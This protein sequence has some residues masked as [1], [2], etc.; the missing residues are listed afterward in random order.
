MPQLKATPASALADEPVHI[1][2]T[3]LPPMQLVTLTAS[4]KDE[5]G[6]LFRS[7]AFYKA[8]EAGELD[9]QEAPSLGGDYVGVHPMGL[10]WS[11]KPER[12]FRRLLK[13]DVMSSP[14]SVTLDIYNSV[15]LLESAMVQPSASQVVQR[16]FRCPGTQRVQIWE[17]RLRGA[18][19]LP[20]GEGPFPGIIDLFGGVGGLVE[21]R[22]SLLATHGFAVLALAYF[23]YED[24]PQL[25]REV[26]LEY[27][28]EAANLLLAHPKIQGPGIG[29]MSVSKGAEIGL[30]MA[31]FLKQVVATVCI[32]GANAIF[33]F[34]LKYRDLVMSP[35]QSF[36]ERM[37]TDVSGAVRLFHYRGDPR[38]KANRQSVLPIEK[39]QGQ[40]LFIIG[41]NDQSIN[42]RE[43]AKQAL[44]QLK[45]HGRSNGRMLVYP[46]AGHLIEPPYAPLCYASR[47]NAGSLILLWGGD[48]VAHAAAQ[49]HAWGEIQ[50]FFRQ[51]LTQTRSQL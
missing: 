28:E 4:L 32:N 9:L 41:E 17:G 45:S 36:M 47:N 38:D 34:P 8:N 2:A 35:I 10:F 27:F 43:Y 19:F 48:P 26:D 29:V 3:G 20:P 33:D 22:A 18:L 23:A 25:L 46:G 50:M 14:F 7:K 39:A 42:S 44:E 5:R 21:F 51:H 6:N 11:L 1:R 12:P 31:C 24:L 30:A 37:E 16:W 49:E 13:K 40:I 15:C